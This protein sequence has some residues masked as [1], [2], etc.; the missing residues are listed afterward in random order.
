[1]KH[2]IL[3]N[4]YIMFIF[5]VRGEYGISTNLYACMCIYIYIY[6][7]LKDKQKVERVIAFEK[8]HNKAKIMSIMSLG[9]ILDW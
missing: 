2:K 4:M 3:I 1:M 5:M 9:K 7:F 6:S 8:R